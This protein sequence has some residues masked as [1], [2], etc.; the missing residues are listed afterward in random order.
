ML[1]LAATA[2]EKIK[3]VPAMFW[4]KAFAVIAGFVV[5]VIVFQKV[6]HMNKLVLG[7][8]IFVVGG[9]VGFRW[10]YERDEPAFMT[11][12]IGLIADSGFFP[13]KGGG[14]LRSL[15]EDGTKAPKKPSAPAP[16]K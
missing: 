4:I 11:P 15:N 10:V 1:L 7:L 5:A 8:I 2:L 6:V 12:I 9:V 13:T 16:K 14:E 3:D